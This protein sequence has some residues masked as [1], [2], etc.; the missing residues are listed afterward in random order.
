MDA[1]AGPED[2]MVASVAGWPW[3]LQV[4]HFLHFALRSGLPGSWS[5]GTA[6][7][8]TCHPT[9]GASP[10]LGPSVVYLSAFPVSCE[11]RFSLEGC[12]FWNRGGETMAA[13]S[14]G[15]GPR[16]A[17]FPLPEGAQMVRRVAGVG[18]GKMSSMPRRSAGPLVSRGRCPAWEPFSGPQGPLVVSGVGGGGKTAPGAA[19]TP[20]G[21]NLAGPEPWWRKAAGV[22]A[23][24]GVW[25]PRGSLLGRVR[26]ETA[27]GA[28]LAPSGATFSGVLG[29]PR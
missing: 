22:G 18:G 24:S 28:V 2:G 25:G 23:F 13:A 21:H 1:D 4:L 26:G 15:T 11:V 8:G 27:P 10:S 6:C 17:W 3:Y 16:A 29:G 9:G 7:G 12:R 20:P 14:A 5:S 19:V